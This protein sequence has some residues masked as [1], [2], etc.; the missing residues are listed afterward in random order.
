MEEQSVDFVEWKPGQDKLELIYKQRLSYQKAY[1]ELGKTAPT[2]QTST[3]GEQYAKVILF[4]ELE[5]L[6]SK[7]DET[8]IKLRAT[9][10]SEIKRLN[11][12]SSSFGND[13]TWIH[14]DLA[15]QLYSFLR[16]DRSETNRHYR[17]A[18]PLSDDTLCDEIISR[19]IGWE[20]W[21]SGGREPW[22]SNV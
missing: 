16:N 11:L 13:D 1:R 5:G 21:Y 2:M 14:W 15:K 4:V 10:N 18:D 3:N 20:F 12:I 6:I 22:I 8:V 17:I 19:R 7:F 9:F